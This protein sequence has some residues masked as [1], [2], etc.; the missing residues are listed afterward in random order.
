MLIT[1]SYL[2][3]SMSLFGNKADT[4]N[5]I[6]LNT[7]YGM[8]RGQE[9]HTNL[10]PEHPIIANLNSIIKNGYHIAKKVHFFF[11]ARKVSQSEKRFLVLPILVKYQI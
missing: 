10:H 5:S 1:I 8:R 11:R 3:A 2:E 7:Y 4:L 9:I 6:V